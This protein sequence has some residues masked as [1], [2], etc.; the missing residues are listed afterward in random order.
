VSEEFLEC[1]LQV[2]GEAVGSSHTPAYLGNAKIATELWSEEIK[3]DIQLL[4]FLVS[5]ENK[6]ASAQFPSFLTMTT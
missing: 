4:T 2:P 6:I 1:H 5:E 3:I